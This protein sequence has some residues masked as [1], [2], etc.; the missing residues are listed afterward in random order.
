MDVDQW[1]YLARH[2][3]G[4][5]PE[6]RGVSRYSD[7]WHPTCI[8]VYDSPGSGASSPTPR[9]GHLS[10]K[11]VKAIS[12]RF[13]VHIIFPKSGRG[14]PADQIRMCEAKRSL[15]IAHKV[16]LVF[17]EHSRWPMPRCCRL[18][19]VGVTHARPPAWRLSMLLTLLSGDT[20][21][22]LLICQF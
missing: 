1:W 12:N 14:E 19:C 21:A 13:R 16:V 8:S 2:Y 20:P 9:C 5:A 4:V 7:S 10:W 11:Q 22:L 15:L 18:V 6:S 3:A 17:A